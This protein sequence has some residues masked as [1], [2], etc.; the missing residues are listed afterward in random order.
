MQK[1]YTFVNQTLMN[2]II[3]INSILISFLIIQW[4]LK[5]KAKY[6]DPINSERLNRLRDSLRRHRQQFNPRQKLSRV[7]DSIRS[8]GSSLSQRFKPSGNTKV[9]SGTNTEFPW[10]SALNAPDQNFSPAIKRY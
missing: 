1:T 7:R 9:S 2:I 4:F 6:N 3:V 8:R 10:R 5:R